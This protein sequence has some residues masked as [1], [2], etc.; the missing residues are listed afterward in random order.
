M[1]SS[2]TSLLGLVLPVQGELQGTWGDTVNNE[3]TSLLDTAV[4]GTTTLSTDA[5]VTLTS[6]TGAANQA[7]QA[8]LLWTATGTVTRN[9]TAPARSKP[10]IVIN[11]TGGTQSIVVRGAGPTT[12]VTLLAGEKAVIAWNG[13]DFIKIANLNGNATFATLAA[14]G[15]LSVTGNASVAGLTATADSSFTSTGALS[16]S[17]GT[18]AEQPGTPATGMVRYNTTTNQ[19]EGYSGAAPAWKSIGGSAL[20]NDTATSTNVYPVF[21]TATTGTAENLYTSNAKYL[22][23]PSTGELQSTALVA[24]NGIVVNSKNVSTSYTIPSGSNAMSAGPV[25][26]DSGIT[27]TV[28]S[29]SR[30]VVV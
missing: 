15:T 8:V 5:D 20:S 2:Y 7:R 22:Y 21:A 14:T 13:S 4:S 16:I 9:I 24:S 1:P 27:V 12:G 19:F 23:K 10:Y 29:G 30:W 3:L 18:T 26:V 28:P 11:A 25:T 6:T 17:K